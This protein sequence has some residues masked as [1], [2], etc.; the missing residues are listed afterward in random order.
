LSRHTSVWRS[1][2]C[3]ARARN[4]PAC[5]STNTVIAAATRPATAAPFVSE[6]NSTHQTPSGHRS[7]WSAAACRASRVF[8]EP[9]EPVIVSRRVLPNRSWTV[10]HSAA[11]PTNGVS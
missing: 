8:P 7:T 1:R 6:P 4:G 9:P 5:G 10:A 2:S 11:R 3:T